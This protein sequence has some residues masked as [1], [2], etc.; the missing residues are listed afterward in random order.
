MAEI[1]RLLE[2]HGKQAVMYLDVDRRVVEAA[3]GYPSAEEGEVGFLY[4][5]WAQS[6]LPHKR[7]ARR[8][9]PNAPCPSARP[10]SGELQQTQLGHCR[11]LPVA[12]PGA[13][14]LSYPLPLTVSSSRRVRVSHRAG[15]RPALP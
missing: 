15:Q 11:P 10:L 7:L 9:V 12:D 13:L 4:S 6:A 2:Q 14:G 5:G 1:H 3:A 8:P